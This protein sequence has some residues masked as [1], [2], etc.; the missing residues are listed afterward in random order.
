MRH[1]TKYPIT[2]LVVLFGAF[3]MAQGV[4]AQTDSAPP[5]ARENGS[6][7]SGIGTALSSGDL[8]E[9]NGRNGVDVYIKEVTGVFSNT[10]QKGFLDHNAIEANHSTFTTG[11][12]TI[13]AG[14]F[15]NMNGV[16]TVI[17]N[18]G[19]QVLIQNATVVDVIV[20]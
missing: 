16:A 4:L 18:S 2:I 7:G 8:E 11:A 12:N 1:F 6:E 13:E 10:D 20:K 3:L 19:N 5:A 14:A 15:S 17:Q 9:M